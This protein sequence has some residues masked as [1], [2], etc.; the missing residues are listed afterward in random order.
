L[1]QFISFLRFSVNFC[2]HSHQLSPGISKI[3]FLLIMDSL[4]RETISVAEVIWKA[5]ECLAEELTAPELF[6]KGAHCAQNIKSLENN[7]HFISLFYR[8]KTDGS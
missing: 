5:V 4:E 8:R 1:S 7:M 6:S 2:K 3:P